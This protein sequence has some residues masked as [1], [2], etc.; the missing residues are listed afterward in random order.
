ERRLDPRGKNESI[1]RY[2]Y[3]P[4][5]RRATKTDSRGGLMRYQYDGFHRY[6]GFT[7]PGGTSKR[8]WLDP[9]GMVTRIQV[10]RG[11]T[12][13]GSE[14]LLETWYHRDELNRLTRLERAW[15]ANSGKALG[16]TAWD[17]T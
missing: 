4:N 16:N 7:N 8:Q 2:T 6:V 9:A 12:R 10:T 13:E 17:K 5:G 14:T 11:E 3:T 15:R 1:T